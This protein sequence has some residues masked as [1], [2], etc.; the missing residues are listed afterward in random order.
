MIGVIFKSALVALALF[1]ALGAA[2]W[3]GIDWALQR[4]GATSGEMRGLAALLLVLGGGWLLW[5]V[6]A[7]AVL[8]FFAN[9]VVQAVEAR[10]YPEMLASA[11]TVPFAEELAEGLKGTGRALL[12]NLIALPVAAMLLVT[13]VGPPLVFL[14]VNAVLLGRELTGM[15]WLRHRH[16]PQ[17]PLPLSGIERLALG[18]AAAGLLTV[19]FVNLLAPVIGAAAATHLVHRKLEGRAHAA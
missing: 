5:R 4:A 12:F 10:H 18:G 15:V 16:D 13:G 17:A 1:A 3:W 9:D 7:L 19:P 6:I 2:A 14:F 8:Q 11:R